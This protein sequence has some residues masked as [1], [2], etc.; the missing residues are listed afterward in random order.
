MTLGANVIK[1]V[2]AQHGDALMQIHNERKEARDEMKES[3]ATTSAAEEP[4]S[5]SESALDTA[6]TI[7]KAIPIVAGTVDGIDK[8]R[9]TGGNAVLGAAKG[10]LA[11]VGRAVEGGVKIL[12]DS[13]GLASP[14]DIFLGAFKAQA[15]N[16]P[17]VSDTTRKVAGLGGLSD[18]LKKLFSVTR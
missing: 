9:A 5:K 6:R 7:G 11:T 14:V 17:G 10:Y 13:K 8:A 4:K 3:T 16:T 18:T 15:E 12:V 1:E 2:S